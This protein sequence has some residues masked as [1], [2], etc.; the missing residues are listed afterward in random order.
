MA[1]NRIVVI[2]RRVTS[3]NDPAV[4]NIYP[5]EWFVTQDTNIIYWKDPVSGSI[6]NLGSNPA[7]TNSTRSTELPTAGTLNIDPNTASVFYTTL[8][9]NATINIANVNTTTTNEVSSFVLEI[10]NGGQFTVNWMADIKWDRSVAP[11]LSLN[12]KTIIGFYGLKRNNSAS[13][14]WTGTVLAYEVDPS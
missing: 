8:V 11:L 10:T 13:Y 1:D 14:F 3:I 5:G 2:N 7:I 9:G 6:K 12:K 4:A